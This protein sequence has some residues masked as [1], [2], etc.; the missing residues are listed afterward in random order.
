MHGESKGKGSG[1]AVCS[2]VTSTFF[3]CAFDAK[4][5]GEG[6]REIVDGTCFRMCQQVHLRVVA[7]N[8]ARI[9]PAMDI[10][11]IQRFLRPYLYCRRRQWNDKLNSSRIISFNWKY[12]LGELGVRPK[13]NMGR[14]CTPNATSA[15]NVEHDTCVAVQEA[16]EL[17]NTLSISYNLYLEEKKHTRHHTSPHVLLSFL[18]RHSLVF[19]LFSFWSSFNHVV[20]RFPSTQW[21]KRR[22]KSTGK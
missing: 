12:R 17:I 9:A 2:T 19:A 18:L 15:T 7:S 11:L 6:K 20:L 14:R 4:E 22:K 8:N 13:R 1:C 10:K 5:R 3:P 16:P 21:K